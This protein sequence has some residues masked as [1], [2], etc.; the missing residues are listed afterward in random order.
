MSKRARIC[1]RL[2]FGTSSWRRLA[3]LN[4]RGE[5]NRGSTHSVKSNTLAHT[6]PLN[7]RAHITLS[8][9]N[10]HPDRRQLTTAT[11]AVLLRA[12]AAVTPSA[13]LSTPNSSCTLLLVPFIETLDSSPLSFL[14]FTI[15]FDG[16]DRP[17]H[18]HSA[19][20]S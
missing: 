15:F 7:C 5:T 17:S 11:R 16:R 9:L 1:R 19:L 6:L 2:D 13:P 12:A 3:S 4:S 8:R 18:P 20:T 14:P 10:S